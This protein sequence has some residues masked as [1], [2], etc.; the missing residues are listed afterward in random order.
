MFMRRGPTPAAISSSAPDAAWYFDGHLVVSEFCWPTKR[1]VLVVDGDHHRAA[2]GERVGH[3][4]GVAHGD[5]D[6]LLRIADAEQQGVA[7]S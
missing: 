4:P 3:D 6:I 7:P 5:R 1:A 2:R